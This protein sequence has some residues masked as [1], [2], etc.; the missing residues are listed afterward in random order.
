MGPLP[1]LAGENWS[2]SGNIRG[3]FHITGN[4]TQFR[5]KNFVTSVDIVESEIL[6]DILFPPLFCDWLTCEVT[7]GGSHWKRSVFIPI[8]KKGNAK[9]VQATVYLRSFHM[10]AR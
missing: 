10:L 5:V 2:R 1:Q 6:L 4:D 3:D 8:P 9:E 7:F